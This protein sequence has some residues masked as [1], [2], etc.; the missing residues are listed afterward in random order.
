MTKKINGDVG[1]LLLIFG[2]MIALSGCACPKN[3]GALSSDRPG[4]TT[5]PGIVPPCYPQ[6][7]LGWTH[8]EDKN[9]SGTGTKNDQCPNTLLRFGVVP[10]AEVRVGY[11]GYNWQKTN[12]EN[13]PGSSSS[14]SSD[15]NVAV[16]YR[17]LQA[18]GWLPESAF[19]G[20]LRV[21]K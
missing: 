16:K 4:A 21:L 11:V 3:P 12:P 8:T 17:F 15:A 1:F 9:A 18:D 7:E 5:S 14:G 20:Q 13:G 19:L 6:L 10:N 2:V